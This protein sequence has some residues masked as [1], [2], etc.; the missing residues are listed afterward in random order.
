MRLKLGREVKDIIT[1]FK[2]HIT[3]CSIYLTGCDVY[4]VQ[5]P[6]G[7]DG[8]HI[9]ARWIDDM[10]LKYTSKKKAIVLPRQI[11]KDPGACEP[12]PVK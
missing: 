3:G 12:A 5:P 6:V 9:D 11:D 4:L 2:G 7:K 10:R 1:G 8:K